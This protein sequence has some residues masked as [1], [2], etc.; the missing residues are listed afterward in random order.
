MSDVN[1][2]QAQLNEYADAVRAKDVDRL[3][4]LYD[5][6]VRVFDAWDRWSYADRAAWRG[7]LEGW[8]GSLG[9]ESVQV[10]FDDIRSAVAGDMGWLSGTVIY[11]ALDSQG[12][13]LRS[14]ESRLS[15]VLARTEG[16]WRIVHEHTSSPIRFS[17]QKGMLSRAG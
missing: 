16:E 15:W 2:F 10:G 13:T 12:V 14:M 6:S 7:N 1:F 9:N 17:D 3:A 5:D 8:L 11:A 4:S